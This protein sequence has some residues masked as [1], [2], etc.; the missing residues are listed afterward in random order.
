[1]KAELREWVTEESVTYDITDGPVVRMNYGVQEF[2]LDMVI[3]YCRK[4]SETG[5]RV[6]RVSGL[7]RRVLKGGRP[8]ADIRDSDWRGYE[9]REGARIPAPDWVTE[10]AR[11]ALEWV[12][13]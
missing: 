7:G 11:L 3:V 4:D 5:W 13:R 10:S 8:G 9:L 12:G 1:M 2:R 6:N